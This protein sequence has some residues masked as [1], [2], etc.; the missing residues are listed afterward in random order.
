MKDDVVSVARVDAIE[1]RLRVIT[2]WAVLSTVMLCGVS[3]V[4]LRTEG[5]AEVIRAKGIVLEDV[6]ASVSIDARSIV[7]VRGSLE[8][9]SFRTEVKPGSVDLDSGNARAYQGT[10]VEPGGV[11]VRDEVGGVSSSLTCGGIRLFGEHGA[12]VGALFAEVDGGGRLE[13]SGA[14]GARTVLDP[15][16][17]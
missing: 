12:E 16:V 8:G 9:V 1:R 2:S 4:A 3:I 6:D 11:Y 17:P 5:G 14:S 15:D 10:S 13:L 7:L